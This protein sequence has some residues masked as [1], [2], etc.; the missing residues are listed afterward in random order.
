MDSLVVLQ[1]ESVKFIILEAKKLR[2]LTCECKNKKQWQTYNSILF[3]ENRLI[4]TKNNTLIKINT[5]DG[6]YTIRW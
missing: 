1:F 3:H 2:K 6:C 5:K 4:F